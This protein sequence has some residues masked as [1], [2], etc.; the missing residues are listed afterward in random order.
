MIQAKLLVIGGEVEVEEISLQLPVTIGR[1]R[2]AVINLSHPLVSRH[3]CELFEANGVLMVR[4]LD[5]MN[6]TFVGSQR[7][8]EAVVR[9]GDLLTVGTVTFR[10]FTIT[11]RPT[12]PK[13]QR[14]RKRVG[15]AAVAVPPPPLAKALLLATTASWRKPT[16]STNERRWKF[17]LDPNPTTGRMN[18]PIRCQGSVPRIARPGPENADTAAS[19]RLTP[20]RL[21]AKSSRS[22]L[23]RSDPSRKN[24]LTLCRRGWVWCFPD[25]DGRG[26]EAVVRPGTDVRDRPG[27]DRPFARP[28]LAQRPDQR[29]G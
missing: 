19:I 2:E 16:A 25:R 3:H 7:V 8:S 12:P 11:T 14:P 13:N 29:R 24:I 26:G 20:I 18:F 28:Y 23:S 17:A 9:P 1:S 5:S 15:P 10:C 4:D 22:P 21:L 6:G 27:L